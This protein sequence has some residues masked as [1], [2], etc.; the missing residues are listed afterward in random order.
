[1]VVGSGQTWLWNGASWSQIVTA[2]AP[3][4]VS[5]LA[6]DAFRSVVV[7]IEPGT[8]V[9]IRTWEFDGVDWTQRFPAS[10]P[11][12]LSWHTLAWDPTSQR[13][14]LRFGNSFG[15]GASAWNGTTWVTVS[16]AG[17][18]LPGASMATAP[19]SGGVL[20]SGGYLFPMYVGGNYLISAT[21]GANLPT[22]GAPAP[23]EY[24]VSWFD[25]TRNRTVVTNTAPG[26]RGTWYWDG[27]SWSQPPNG[28]Q[29]PLGMDPLVYD[30]W[31]GRVLGFGGQW[32]FGYPHREVWQLRDGVAA[33]LGDGPS[34]RF[35]HAAAF[36]SWRGR[37][38]VFGGAN[39]DAGGGSY[40]PVYDGGVT[41]EWDGTSWTWIPATAWTPPLD[42]RFRLRATMAFDRARGRTVLFGGAPVT[43]AGTYSLTYRPDTF[44]WDGSV[45]TAALP[46]TLPPCTGVERMEF[47]VERAQC[48]LFAGGR[49]WAWNGADWTLLA[50]PQLTGSVR[51]HYDPARG[52]WVAFA[53]GAYLELRSG[54]WQQVATS[55]LF[56][57]KAFDLAQGRFAG[58]DDLGSFTF[59]DS[60][61]G[62]L[63]PEGDG[64]IGSAG[65]PVLHGEDAPRVGRTLALSLANAPGGAIF[66][67]MLG[68]ETNAWLGLALPIVLDPLGMPG[69][70]LHTAID[71]H[72]LRSGGAWPIVIPATTALLG[73]RYR[74][75][76]LV[77]D[78]AANAFGATTSNS[79]RLRIGS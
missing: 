44:E 39:A 48:V 6:F 37:W 32:F 7:A 1:L 67:G 73:S 53:N 16:Q 34:A 13:C 76:A 3:G 47:D 28:T 30:S 35:G 74:V 70:L 59:G 65:R 38:I 5:T 56:G 50:I 20:V 40:G 31:R 52:I 57:P 17:F 4:I 41:H 61:A 11:P 78:V 36:D 66:A 26:N 27:L 69:C 68:G 21:G 75:Q 45:W 23:R 14:L 29:I 22:I 64:C 2:H 46:T 9:A 51:V 18:A 42:P 72:E 49:F 33:Q 55:N 15:S 24:S 43:A 58:S 62:T 54:A 10:S 12:T 63:R 8:S 25:A 79:L 77:F 71:T 60:A 19:G